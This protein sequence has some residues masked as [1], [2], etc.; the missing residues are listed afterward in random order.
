M[1]SSRPE[2]NKEVTTKDSQSSPTVSHF[3]NPLPPTQTFWLPPLNLQLLLEN[4]G[5]KEVN[6]V[7]QDRIIIG[8]RTPVWER[9]VITQ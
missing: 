2:T 3:H 7:E 4:L 5:V 1:S 6:W 9:M 8:G